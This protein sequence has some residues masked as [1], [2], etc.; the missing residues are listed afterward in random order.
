MGIT[1]TEQVKYIG[2]ADVED[3]PLGLKKKDK[4]AAAVAPAAGVCSRISS[5]GATKE[6][7]EAALTN[8]ECQCL[9]SCKIKLPQEKIH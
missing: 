8:S 9:A 3:K 1:S 5:T 4:D 7:F 2:D 6:A